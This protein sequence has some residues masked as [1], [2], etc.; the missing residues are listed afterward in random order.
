MLVFPKMVDVSKQ[1]VVAKLFYFVLSPTATSVGRGA[2][3][4][5]AIDRRVISGI[6]IHN[7]HIYIVAVRCYDEGTWSK[8]IREHYSVTCTRQCSLNVFM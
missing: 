1:F 2:C 4:L 7:S 5:Q 3:Y 6:Y 8:F